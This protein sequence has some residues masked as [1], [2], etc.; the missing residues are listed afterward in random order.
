MQDFDRF[1][2]HGIDYGVRERRQREFFCAAAVAGPASVGE[3]FQKANALIDCPHGRL[4]EMRI[5][6]LQVVLDVLEIVSG[7]TVQRMRIRPCAF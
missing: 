3:G 2:F 7:G 5:V 1:G 4:C 6:L